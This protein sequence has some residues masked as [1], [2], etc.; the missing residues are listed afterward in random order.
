MPEPVANLACVMQ[1]AAII[2]T[3]TQ[4]LIHTLGVVL[5]IVP[6]EG[7]SYVETAL[8]EFQLTCPLHDHTTELD[9]QTGTPQRP[10]RST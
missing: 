2:A 3:P 5:S 9:R 8:T 1:A 4:T 7:R 6:R 10:R